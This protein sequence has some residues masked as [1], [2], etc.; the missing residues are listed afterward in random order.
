MD[1]GLI[2]RDLQDSFLLMARFRNRIVHL[3]DEVGDLEVFRFIMQ[4]LDDFRP[5][6]ANVVRKYL[7]DDTGK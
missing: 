7:G 1:R 6:V 5:F 2:P 4:H 3:Y